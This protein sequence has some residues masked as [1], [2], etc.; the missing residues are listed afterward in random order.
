M[1]NQRYYFLEAIEENSDS[2]IIAESASDKNCES[3]IC[4]LSKSKPFCQDLNIRKEKFQNA[5]L[6]TLGTISSTEEMEVLEKCFS[7]TGPLLTAIKD[8]N[9][10]SFQRKQC[11]VANKNIV[12]QRFFPRKRRGSRKPIRFHIQLQ[13]N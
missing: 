8:Q 2:L 6:E 3:A 1:I 5:I 13:L 4:E 7:Q 12:P 9:V 11:F 10:S